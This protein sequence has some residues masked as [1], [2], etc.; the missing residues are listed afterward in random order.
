M[1]AVTIS[2]LCPQDGEKPSLAFEHAWLEMQI[3]EMTL[4]RSCHPTL[5]PTAPV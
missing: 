5:V 1:V 2:Y 4:Q 3:N